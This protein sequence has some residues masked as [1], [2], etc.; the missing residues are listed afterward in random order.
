[1]PKSIKKGTSL[2]LFKQQRY[3]LKR[4]NDVHLYKYKYDIK[5]FV[6]SSGGSRAASSKEEGERVIKRSL[7]N[8]IFST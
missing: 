1:M 3:P 4:K 2:T 7:S 6:T 8:S 5:D